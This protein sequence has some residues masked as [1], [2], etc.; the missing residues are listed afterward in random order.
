MPPWLNFIQPPIYVH[1]CP[2]AKLAFSRSEMVSEISNVLRA[3]GQN[4]ICI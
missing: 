4:C 2:H 1:L 3:G